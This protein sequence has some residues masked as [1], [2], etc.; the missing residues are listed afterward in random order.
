MMMTVYCSFRNKLSLAQYPTGRA[1]GRCGGSSR[2][3]QRQRRCRCGRQT[4]WAQPPAPQLGV[5]CRRLERRRRET[6]RDGLM[7]VS[8]RGADTKEGHAVFILE[9]ELLK[10]AAS[11]TK[12]AR[13]SAAVSTLAPLL[14]LQPRLRGVPAALHTLSLSSRQSASCLHSSS[15]VK[16]HMP[17]ACTRI[18]NFSASPSVSGCDQATM[19]RTS[20]CRE[21]ASGA[22][23]TLHTR[24]KRRLMVLRMRIDVG[25]STGAFGGVGDTARCVLGCNPKQAAEKSSSATDRWNESQNESLFCCPTKPAALLA[26]PPGAA[27]AERRGGLDGDIVATRA[28]V[29]GA[30]AAETNALKG[31]IDSVQPGAKPARFFGR[32]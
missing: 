25:V 15:S 11:S 3:S 32:S 10:S 1:R 26:P 19:R 9:S 14:D 31:P 22:N 7:C 28:A 29:C 17:F 27:S 13:A 4:D 20:W 2:A 24:G 5:C 6:C 18:L 12:M 21:S 23:G 16:C 30:I 8:G